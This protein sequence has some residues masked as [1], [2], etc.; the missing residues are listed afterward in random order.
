MPRQLIGEALRLPTERERLQQLRDKLQTGL[1][2]L[3]RGEG[4][5]FTIEWGAE[6]IRIARERAAAGE[7]PDPDVC[8]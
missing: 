2:P 4:I 1:D 7:Q 6:R 3:D 8:P 5:P